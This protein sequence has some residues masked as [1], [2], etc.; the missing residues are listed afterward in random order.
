MDRSRSIVLVAVLAAASLGLL[1][2]ATILHGSSQDVGIASQ[3]TGASVTVDNQMLGHTPVV[4]KLKRKDK[5]TIAVALDGYQPFEVTTTRSTSGW[6]W[7]NIVFG[8]LIG[9]AVDLSTGGAY[10]IHPEQVSAQ[11]GRAAASATFT[12]GTLYVVL[13]RAPDSSW[14]KIGQLEP[15][16]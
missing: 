10:K 7:G 16:R 4:A 11:L 2:C 13:V 9:L 14:E 3:P 6:V 8:G 15:L 5:H 12:E 1:A